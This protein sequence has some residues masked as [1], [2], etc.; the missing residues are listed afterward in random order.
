MARFSQV[1]QAFFGEPDNEVL[2]K[3][4]NVDLT[5]EQL[6][7]RVQNVFTQFQQYSSILRIC[8]SKG[9]LLC[10][11]NPDVPRFSKIQGSV[12]FATLN[13]CIRLW[14]VGKFSLWRGGGV[15]HNI[16]CRDVVL[17]LACMCLRDSP[18]A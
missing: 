8:R 9:G 14:L 6:Q 11:H 7:V 5:R 4:F 16:T 2:V 3:A 13:A 15:I 18:Q 1:D 12:K 17:V 10:T